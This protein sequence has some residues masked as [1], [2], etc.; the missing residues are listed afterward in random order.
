M[1]YSYAIG[2]FCIIVVRPSVT[3]VLWL[4]VRAYVK[5]FTLIISPVS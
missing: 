1:R 5:T 3:D 2:D 4:I